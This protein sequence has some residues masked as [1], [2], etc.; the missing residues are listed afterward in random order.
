MFLRNHG[1]DLIGAGLGSVSQAAAT[2]LTNGNQ[3]RTL[4]SYYFPALSSDSLINVPFTEIAISF[5]MNC[6]YIIIDAVTTI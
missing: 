2:V 1:Q 3:G 6:N 4:K 5:M